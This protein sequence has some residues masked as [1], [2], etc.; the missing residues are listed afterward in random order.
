MITIGDL[1]NSISELEFPKSCQIVIISLHITDPQS[2]NYLA[3]V[4]RYI[5]FPLFGQKVLN[6]S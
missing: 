5:Q 1:E 2:L 3:K 6:A 4:R